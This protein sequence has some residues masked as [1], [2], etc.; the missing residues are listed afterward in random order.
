MSSHKVFAIMLH[1]EKPSIQLRGVSPTFFMAGDRQP[2]FVL[3]Y[4]SFSNVL[5]FNRHLSN[6]SAVSIHIPSTTAHSNLSIAQD[7]SRF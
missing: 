5:N 2:S 3:F 6:S 4:N 7:T 1:K